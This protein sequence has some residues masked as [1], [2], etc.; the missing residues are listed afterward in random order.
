MA[1]SFVN[2][3]SASGE[4]STASVSLPANT[5]SGDLL[6]WIVEVYSSSTTYSDP[7][8][9][10]N[11]MGADTY[12]ATDNN[13]RCKVWTRVSDGGESPS[14]T[15]SASRQWATCIASY[16]GV[17]QSTPYST[18]EGTGWSITTLTNS[19]T[20]LQSVAL[21]AS[22]GQW[23][24]SLC[25]ASDTVASWT[26]TNDRTE[27]ADISTATQGGLAALADSDGSVSGSV[28]TTFSYSVT[29]DASRVMSILLNEAAAGGGAALNRPT[30][31][32]TV[33]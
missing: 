29:A 20:S 16:R 31:F 28:T 8:G 1:I 5:V 13:L 23:L 7:S 2:P 32:G 22:S 26:T 17:D 4:S 15:L 10:T 14:A 3:N 19:A 27:R 11:V 33:W 25:G 21:T 9:W 12:F 30:L 6:V 24:V 18:T